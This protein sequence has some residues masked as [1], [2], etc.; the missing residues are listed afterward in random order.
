M[1]GYSLLS[2]VS[3]SPLCHATILTEILG[4]VYKA[5][6]A[7]TQ[8]AYDEGVRPLFASLDRLEELLKG[9]DYIVGNRLTEVDIRLFPAIVSC[10]GRAIGM[11]LTG[12]GQIR[13]DPVYYGCFKCNLKS[14]RADYPEIH[15]WMKQLYW[16]PNSDAFKETV[17]PEH[18]TNGYWVGIARVS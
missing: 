13:F 16:G 2:T 8:Q 18:I 9:K 15:R 7:A 17:V 6:F 14:I 10:C 12:S 5:G 3:S 11:G 4:G 1:T